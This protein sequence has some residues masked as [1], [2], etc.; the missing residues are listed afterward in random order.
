MDNGFKKK[1]AKGI[2]NKYIENNFSVEQLLS[3]FDNVPVSIVILNEKAESVYCN[4]STLELYGVDFKETFYGNFY[5]LTPENQPDGRNSKL[6]FAEHVLSAIEKGKEHFNWLDIKMTGKELQLF[7][8]IFSLNMTDENGNKLLVSTMRDLS[9]ELAG[10]EENSIYDEYYYNRVTY[11]DLFNT[12]AE[13]TEEWFWVH[14]VKM[15]TIQF[16]GKGREILG[17]SSEKQPFPSYV[18]D[19]GMVYPDD[20]EGFLEFSEN[21]L[22]GVV[23]P[24][25]VRFIGVDGVE[26][27]YRITYKT[28]LDKD[29][30]PRFSIG[31]TYDIDT[32]KR[33]ET[34]SQTDQLTKCLNKMTTEN[35][36]KKTLKEYPSSTHAIFIID[37]DDFKSVNSELG[38]FFGDIVLRDIAQKLH[39]NFRGDDIVGRI[40]GDEFLVLAKNLS[41]E[42][43]IKEKA[44]AISEAFKTSYSGEKKDYKISGSIGVALYPKD[45]ETYESLYKCADKALYSSKIAG[46]DR[47]TI[48]SDDIAQ[49][50]TKNLTEVDHVD[51][52]DGSYFEQ[53]VISAAFDLMFEAKDTEVTMNKIVR[54]LGAHM[55]G[56]RCYISQTFDGGKTYGITYEWTVNKDLELIND[57]QS[58]P[59]D[60]VVRLFAE[61]EEK[62]V[63]FNKGSSSQ[64][65]AENKKGVLESSNSFLITQTKGKGE[66]RLILGVNDKRSNRVWK[67]EE[68]HTIQH[69][70]KMISLYLS[71]QG[72]R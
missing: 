5:N 29:D 20:L 26:R 70:V 9:P 42:D 15:R 64:S 50:D 45:G 69:V 51:K 48:Y 60:E 40:G 36:V 58:I 33:L 37:V 35:M 68:I 52:L 34:L 47:Y 24:V 32:E 14:D 8:S 25:D 21:V 1:N 38:H 7:I 28:I 31:K 43:L 4:A 39:A 30:A 16:F 3:I 61:L 41:S 17:L 10:E 19:S 55:E 56:D 27:F 6:A 23:A 59:R 65:T 54:L 67:E 49:G 57:F 44:K 72:K 22:N 11:K 53:E 2:T 66:G 18:V 62:G 71:A 13:L 63:M 46:K 12:V